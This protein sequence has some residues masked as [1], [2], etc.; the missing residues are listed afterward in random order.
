MWGNAE[1]RAALG[2]AN[3]RLVR[4][5]AGALLLADAGRVFMDGE[6]AGGWHAAYGG[7]VWFSMIDGAYTATL[8]AARGDEGWRAYLRLGLPF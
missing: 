7:G 4:G 5:N 1:L 8:L 2:R 3:L 6:S